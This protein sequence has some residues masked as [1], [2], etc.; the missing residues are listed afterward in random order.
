MFGQLSRPNLVTFNAC[1]S[2]CEAAQWRHVLELLR[3]M[4]LERLRGDFVTFSSAVSACWRSSSL[5]MPVL[6]DA[7]Q[8]FAFGL[9]R[10]GETGQG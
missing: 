5:A 3:E 7:L 8:S 1:F 10:A 2:A 9:K 6:L 4:A